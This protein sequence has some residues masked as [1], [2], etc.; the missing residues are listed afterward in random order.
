MKNFFKYVSLNI[1]GMI[2]LSCYIVADTFFISKDMGAIGIASL[3]FSISIYSVIYATGLMI[4]IGGA[5]R[6]G[7]LKSKEHSDRANIVFNHSVKSGVG[8]GMVFALIGALGSKYLASLLGARGEV[9]LLVDIYLK[10]ILVFSPFFILNNVILAFVRN[11][12]NPRLSM[13]AMLIGSF[14]N[15]LLDYIFIFMLNLGMFG[16]ALATSIAPI[17]SLICLSVHFLKHKNGFAFSKVDFDIGV[18]ID[19]IGLGLSAFVAEI[20]SGI[21]LISFNLVILKLAGNIGVAAYG[22]IANIALVGVSVF[23]GLAQGIQPILSRAYGRQDKCEVDRILRYGIFSAVSIAIVIY[24]CMLIFSNEIIGAFNSEG[25]RLVFEMANRGVVI[26]FAGFL[27]AGINIVLMMYLS[28]IERVKEAFK[29][30]VLRGGLL[31]IPLVILLSAI[32]EMDGV[33]LSFIVNEFLVCVLAIYSVKD[34]SRS[35]IFNSFL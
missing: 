34:K 16:A 14:S 6:Y 25:N 28:V 4:G 32:W 35:L 7:I 9:L 17:I 5:S 33:W 19:L 29:I 30:S 2:G 10:V 22:I 3:N 15:I 31:I 23:T 24:I 13:L 12:N 26:Y 21:V 27:F 18:L 8:I 20:S 11:D 1:A